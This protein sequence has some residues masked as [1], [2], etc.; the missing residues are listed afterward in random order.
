MG[1]GAYDDHFD[2]CIFYNTLTRCSQD[3]MREVMGVCKGEKGR[4]IFS[5]YTLN[6]NLSINYT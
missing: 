1:F 3:Q 6:F 4:S 5:L 2:V